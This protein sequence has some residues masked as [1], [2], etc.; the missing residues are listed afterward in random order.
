MRAQRWSARFPLFQRL[1]RLF[2]PLPHQRDKRSR[3]SRERVTCFIE[4]SDA[5]ARR[6]RPS[7]SAVITSA[8]FPA[9]MR[10]S[11]WSTKRLMPGITFFD[12][13]WEYYNG[14]TENILG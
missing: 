7:E 4:A 12:N 13:C 14:K 10:R 11:G 6:Y 2:S 3:R 1:A 9:W 8:I 5:Q